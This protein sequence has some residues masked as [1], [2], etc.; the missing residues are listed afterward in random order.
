M[1]PDTY[2]FGQCRDTVR[3]VKGRVPVYMGIGV[4]APRVQA[5]QAACTPDH[6]YR[7]VKATY[8]A[9]G[10]GVIFSPNYAGMNLTSLDGAGKALAELGL[11]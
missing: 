9:G 4:D 6:V 10:R 7:S 1:D 2:T 5:D 11:K 8:R 3:A